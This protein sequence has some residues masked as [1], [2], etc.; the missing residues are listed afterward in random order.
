MSHG[1]RSTEPTI[2]AI[3]AILAVLALLASCGQGPANGLPEET[4]ATRSAPPPVSSVVDTPSALATRHEAQ[5]SFNRA[6]AALIRND[7]ATSARE[8]TKASAFM[9][10]HAEEAEIGAIAAL[11]GAS[12]ELEVLAERIARGEAQTI[13]TLDRVFAN[14]NRAEAQHH[15][16]RAVAAMADRGYRRAGEE[17][18]MSVD[19]LE[20]AARDLPRSRD[21]ASE[22]TIAEARTVAVGMVREGAATRGE[23]K[24]VIAALEAELRRLCGIIDVEARAC[25]LDSTR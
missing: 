18:L 23:A 9:R 13:R 17:L 22:A 19:H 3:L 7:S 12:K 8:L 1:M 21:P 10:M 5:E 16:T 2:F 25:A 14:A 15:L 11:Q 4:A 20:R 24:R 6:R